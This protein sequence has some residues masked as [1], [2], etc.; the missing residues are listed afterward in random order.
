MCHTRTPIERGAAQGHPLADRI[1]NGFHKHQFSSMEQEDIVQRFLEAL[2][3]RRK[4]ISAPTYDGMTDVRKFLQTFG[5]VAQQNAWDDDERTLH[6]KLAL[7]GPAADCA[8]GDTAEEIAES[9][10]TRY[11]LTREEAR[12]EL[13]N[14]RLRAGQ[15]IHLFGN[16]VMK[17]VRIAEPELEGDQLD[18]RATAELVDA[19]G[20]RMLTREFRL[21]APVNFADA[22]RR[23]SQYNSDM[24]TARVC[25]MGIG[26]DDERF[27]EM[28][29]RITKLEK[30]QETLRDSV[31]KYCKVNESAM[32]ALAT[33]LDT[34]LAANS[35]GLSASRGN[36]VRCQNCQKAG[37]TAKDCWGLLSNQVE[38]KCY[39]CNQVGHLARQ[40]NESL[41]TPP[42]E[43]ALNYRGPE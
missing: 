31:E 24:R 22:I 35:F 5:E 39:R 4:P 38:R 27:Q 11:E 36:P 7:K 6:L 17:L 16:L 41:A 32:S 28:E 10:L 14:L 9:L 25:H 13:R 12:R 3:R 42:P 21:R 30:S 26:D 40:C 19:I 23:I 8:H 37:H 43:Q 18:D 33:K 15:D 1:P 34:L 29:T 2:N 20:E